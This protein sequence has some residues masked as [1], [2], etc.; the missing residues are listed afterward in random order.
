MPQKKKSSTLDSE[1]KC[2]LMF[3]FLLVCVIVGISLPGF[4]NE[5]D[6]FGVWIKFPTKITPLIKG[7]E[8]AGLVLFIVC[9]CV[10]VR[11]SICVYMAV[12]VGK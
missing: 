4:F 9:V 1:E 6:D 8:D 10:C 11:V 7:H 3:A 2:T 12:F 5:N